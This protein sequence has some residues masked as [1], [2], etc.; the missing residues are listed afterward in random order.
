MKTK[1]ILCALIIG[2][3]GWWSCSDDDETLVP[4]DPVVTIIEL[5]QGDHDY[6][7]RIVDFY[8][9]TGVYL[10]YKFSDKEIYYNVNNS[11]NVIY[12]DT[13]LILEMYTLGEYNYVQ[14]GVFYM[15]NGDSCPLGES[16]TEDGLWREVIVEGDQV[17]YTYENVLWSGT[18]RVEEADEAHV[19]KQLTL[20]EDLFL[21]YYSDSVLREAMPLKVLL[22]QNLVYRS[23]NRFLQEN[24]RVNFNNLIFNYGNETVDALTVSQKKTIKSELN[25]WFIT[26]RIKPDLSFDDFWSVSTY[27]WSTSA[28][29]PSTA[30]SYELGYIVRPTT[31]TGA[32]YKDADLLNYLS[33]IVNNSYETLTVQPASGEYNATDYTGI[34]H[35]DKDTR[36]L[37]RQKYDILINVFKK[38]GID[39]QAIGND[40]IVN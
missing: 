5:P 25:L 38:A 6:D 10:L 4:S 2:L 35:P 9:R 33:M 37:I 27:N 21:G 23:S 13:T 17:S 39:L 3:T 30:T 36:G 15:S 22:G 34:L 7:T 24:Y 32:L 18:F 26:G 8:H 29:R 16:Y 20:L 11:W 28:G 40:V 19:G 1:Y 14:D 31:S 12:S